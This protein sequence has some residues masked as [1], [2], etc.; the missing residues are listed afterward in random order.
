MDAD[1]IQTLLAELHRELTDA[2]TLPADVADEARAVMAELGESLP[3]EGEQ[4]G[5][6][7]RLEGMAAGFEAEHPKLAAAARQ[8]ATALGRMGI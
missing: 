5:A 1:K 3:A 6:V 7:E 4:H 2:E 8:I